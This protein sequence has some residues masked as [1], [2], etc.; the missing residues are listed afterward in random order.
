MA[1]KRRHHLPQSGIALVLFFLPL[2][3]FAT[4][5]DLNVHVEATVSEVTWL[6]L[7][8]RNAPSAACPS[9]PLPATTSGTLA[10]SSEVWMLCGRAAD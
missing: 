5:V 8:R 4:T 6:I 10:P 7:R 9:P 1:P 2:F 3:L